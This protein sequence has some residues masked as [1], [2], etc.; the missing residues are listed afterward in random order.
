MF[1]V[2]STLLGVIMEY[3][4]W[5]YWLE[6]GKDRSVGKF[7]HSVHKPEFNDQK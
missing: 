3:N 4:K 6:M 2:I 1:Q 7:L 5:E